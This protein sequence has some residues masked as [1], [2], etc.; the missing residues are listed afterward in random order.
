MCSE[1]ETGNDARRP[2]LGTETRC[3]T[4]PLEGLSV[5]VYDQYEEG[6]PSRQR[7]SI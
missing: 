1:A 6:Q 7:D 2:R 5:D 4:A 3:L